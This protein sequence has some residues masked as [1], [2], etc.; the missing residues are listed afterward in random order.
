MKVQY[1]YCIIQLAVK[2]DYDT[3]GTDPKPPTTLGEW[4]IKIVPERG[5]GGGNKN[6]IIFNRIKKSG[7]GGF[8]EGSGGR[9]CAA[10][11]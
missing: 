11:N 1:K 2:F 7:G 9:A 3:K 5:S 4:G 6:R 8:F 10:Y